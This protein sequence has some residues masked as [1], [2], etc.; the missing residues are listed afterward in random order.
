MSVV[1]RVTTP[2]PLPDTNPRAVESVERT[3]AVLGL[4]VEWVHDAPGLVLG[5]IIPQLVNE[6][7]FAV[8]EGIATPRYMDLALTVGLNHPCGPISWGERIGWQAVLNRIHALWTD[9]HDPRYRAAPLLRR[10]AATG[11][12]VRELVGA[13]RGA[14]G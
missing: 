13:P 6:A 14:W 9:R 4:H 10:A 3:A 11:R 2:T 12:S 7:S 8:G 5:R 1:A